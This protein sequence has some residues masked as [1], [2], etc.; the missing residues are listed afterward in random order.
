MEKKFTDGYSVLSSGLKI[1]ELD[2]MEC[3]A[4]KSRQAMKISPIEYEIVCMK[5]GL[6]IETS[7]DKI[8]KERWKK[9]KK[10]LDLE[11]SDKEVTNCVKR[12]FQRIEG[13]RARA[14]SLREV[15]LLSHLF[16]EN[17]IDQII[18]KHLDVKSEFILNSILQR[19]SF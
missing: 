7:I 19:L 5:C 6:V 2:E 12:F 8:I 10:E 16:S 1:S 4:C 18:K 15:I 13:A 17:L 14:I 9:I 11:N 3:P